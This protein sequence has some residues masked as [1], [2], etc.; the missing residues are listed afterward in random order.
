MSFSHVSIAFAKS[1]SAQNDRETREKG[2][3][4]TCTASS[5]FTVVECPSQFLKLP[6]I[7]NP[8]HSKLGESQLAISSHC[9][10]AAG[11]CSTR[12][13]RGS[14]VV[15]RGTCEQHRASAPASLLWAG[16]LP[17]AAACSPLPGT[18]LKPAAVTTIL[19]PSLQLHLLDGHLEPKIIER[20]EQSLPHQCRRAAGERSCCPLLPVLPFGAPPVLARVCL[21][22][23]FTFSNLTL[24]IFMGAGQPWCCWTMAA[25]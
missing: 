12:R 3:T 25:S 8:A 1:V 6:T 14:D 20:R 4:A 16:A 5:G 13:R 7:G 21:S 24:K 17:A 9:H 23:A 22:L 11:P 15:V 18:K 2:C 19:L 10:A